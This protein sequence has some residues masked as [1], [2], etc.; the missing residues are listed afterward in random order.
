M[1]PRRRVSRR[2]GVFDEVFGQ[3]S[4]TSPYPRARAVW[5]VEKQGFRANDR[6]TR[7][8]FPHPART[9]QPYSASR[10]DKSPSAG[11]K[12]TRSRVVNVRNGNIRP[13]GDRTLTRRGT[14]RDR[15]VDR[16]GGGQ[17]LPTETSDD[18]HRAVDYLNSL[19][20]GNGHK[21]RADDGDLD[22]VTDRLPFLAMHDLRTVL[23]RK[24]RPNGL[25][26]AAQAADGR[27]TPLGVG[28]RRAGRCAA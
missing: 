21:S 14:G 1:V 20:N 26:A 27:K 12:W 22:E 4:P 13:H 24:K 3:I 18:I 11:S 28:S 10:P 19:T 9:A 8:L 5:S 2:G 15:G 23:V 25:M 6:A 17:F 16:G 7:V